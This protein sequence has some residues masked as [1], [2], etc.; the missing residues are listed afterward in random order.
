MNVS[1]T[2]P[3][4][5]LPTVGEAGAL[6]P[7]GILSSPEHAQAALR[8]PAKCWKSHLWGIYC[9]TTA[10]GKFVTGGQA[11]FKGSSKYCRQ[12]ITLSEG[13][14][15]PPAPTGRCSQAQGSRAELRIGVWSA[16]LFCS[17]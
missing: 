6:L 2:P 1:L 14:P 16:S 10:V 8:L 5:P 9:S 7:T 3:C 12:L 11:A 15:F 13:A 17:A 4:S